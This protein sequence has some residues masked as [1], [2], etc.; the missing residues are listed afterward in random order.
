MIIAEGCYSL[1]FANTSGGSPSLIGGVHISGEDYTYILDDN[2]TFPLSLPSG[3]ELRFIA[4]EALEGAS[5]EDLQDWVDNNV[6]ANNTSYTTQS[7]FGTWSPPGQNIEPGV[8]GYEIPTFDGTTYTNQGFAVA[9]P[10]VSGVAQRRYG[11]FNPGA[12]TVELNE[13]LVWRHT[14]ELGATP[15]ADDLADYMDNNYG[16]WDPYAEGETIV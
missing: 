2:V 6:S 15:T 13:A 1:G 3:Q 9:L 4:D 5:I 8:G 16:S 7:V 10:F 12:V 14:T 11:M